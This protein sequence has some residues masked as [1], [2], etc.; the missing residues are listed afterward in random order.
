MKVIMLALSLFCSLSQAENGPCAIV[1]V[2]KNQPIGYLDVNGRAQGVHWD[3]MAMLSAKSGLCM[4]PRL[5]PYAR[6]WQSLELGVSD[7]SIAF[8]S[9][10]R[11]INFE[12]VAL[13]RKVQTV[14]IARKGIKLASYDDL[15]NI[16]IGKTRGTKLSD[17]F[18]S[19]QNLQLLELN[20]YEQAIKMLVAG[21]I[22][23]IAGSSLVLT[24]QLA[25][26]DALNEM[27]MTSK[28]ILGSR[29]QWLHMSKK[30]SFKS[31][32]PILVESVKQLIKFG[33]FDAVMDKHYK[34]LDW[35]TVNR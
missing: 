3:Y 15:K 28:V 8:S 10:D 33:H 31:Q 22:D 16:R 2:I 34:G 29:E 30:S 25:Q 9:P 14:V 5:L 11:G 23:A 1:G 4:R 26:H 20:G 6:I 21:R 27:D 7:L 19:D 12:R 35:R 24:Y 18:D 17:R 32:I 13:I